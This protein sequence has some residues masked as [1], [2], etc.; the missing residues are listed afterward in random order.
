MFDHDTLNRLYRYC[1][2]L[3]EQDSDAFDLLQSAMERC[4]KAPPR[5]SSAAVS[6]AMKIIRN[7]F[8]DQRRSDARVMLEPFEEQGI[9]VD[10][11]LSSLENLVLDRSELER[12]WVELTVVEREILYLWAVEGYSTDEVAG[13]LDKPRNTVLSIIH[14]MRQRLKHQFGDARTAG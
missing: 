3:C 8:I 6:Y 10:F 11:D 7:I 5:E 14:R 1:R 4:V 13:Q 12:V 9:A 2:S